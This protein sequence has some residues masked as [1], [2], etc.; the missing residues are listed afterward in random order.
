MPKKKKANAT[1]LG[2]DAAVQDAF[3]LDEIDKACKEIEDEVA[4][5]EKGEKKK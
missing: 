3:D 2:P 4:K 1:K 5:R